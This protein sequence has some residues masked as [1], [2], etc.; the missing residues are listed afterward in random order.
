MEDEA[1]RA[2]IHQK[3]LVTKSRAV[4]AVCSLKE[5][6][7]ALFTLLSEAQRIFGHCLD[8]FCC[9][10]CCNRNKA[11][12]LVFL[13]FLRQAN[14][15]TQNSFCCWAHLFSILFSV[16]SLLTIYLLHLDLW[17]VIFFF[18]KTRLSTTIC[19]AP[20]QLSDN[21][22]PCCVWFK[23]SKLLKLAAF[24]SE[25]LFGFQEPL[26]LAWHFLSISKLLTGDAFE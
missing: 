22:S 5:Q 4:S 25:W 18:C 24:L 10:D 23:S 3:Q 6:F 16:I 17:H 7:N 26:Y 2:E 9:C 13:N 21:K 11:L 8:F 12:W 20:F 15:S 19:L 14:I 1:K